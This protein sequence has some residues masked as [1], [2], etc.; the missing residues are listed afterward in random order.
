MRQPFRHNDVIEVGGDIGKVIRLTSRATI[1]LSL[2]GNHICIPNATI[3]KSRIINYSRGPGR[4]FQFSMQLPAGVEPWQ[5][6]DRGLAELGRLD[7]VLEKPAPTAWIE[8]AGDTDATLC[9]SGWVNQ[10]E[11]HSERARGEA[12]RLVNLALGKPKSSRAKA[13]KVRDVS[14]AA[15]GAENAELDSLVESDRLANSESDLLTR[16]G[17]DE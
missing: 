13:P 3:F 6:Q 16:G 4:R 9:F 5:G 14:A 1:L 15:A 12:M 17:L 10:H 7:F 11:S 2:N 8:K